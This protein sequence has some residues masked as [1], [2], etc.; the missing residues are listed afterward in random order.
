MKSLSET[1]KIG[2]LPTYLRLLLLP[3]RSNW[4]NKR[5]VVIGMNHN[6]SNYHYYFSSQQWP[7]SLRIKDDS[8]KD[9][10]LKKLPP[11]NIR[12]FRRPLTFSQSHISYVLFPFRDGGTTYTNIGL[13]F[14]RTT[15]KILSLPRL[16]IVLDGACHNPSANIHR[17]DEFLMNTRAC[18][19]LKF[20]PGNVR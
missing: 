11:K 10:E 5:D 19:M 2:N 7:L 4:S 17:P 6:S 15:Y 18:S 1:A 3:A 20:C 13:P 14:V 8:V 12:M 16:A 9:W